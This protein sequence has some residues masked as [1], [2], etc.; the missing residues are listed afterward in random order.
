FLVRVWPHP[1]CDKRRNA[2]INARA[3]NDISGERQ[4]SRPV[5]VGGAHG[6]V[7]LRRRTGKIASLHCRRWY[8]RLHR[9]TLNQIVA[10]KAQEVKQLVSPDGTADSPTILVIDEGE[11]GKASIGHPLIRLERLVRMIF[12][13]RPM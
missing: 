11:F 10:F 4:S 7:D 1:G 2:R 3:G 9:I 6:V 13:Q 5:R 8:L 12:E